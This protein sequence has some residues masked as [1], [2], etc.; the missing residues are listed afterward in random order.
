[1]PESDWIYRKCDPKETIPPHMCLETT[2]T[3][4]HDGRRNYSDI[5]R[6]KKTKHSSSYEKYENIGSTNNTMLKM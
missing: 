1:M 2:T 4:A 6:A 3:C 5:E